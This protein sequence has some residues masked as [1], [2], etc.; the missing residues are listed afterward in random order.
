MLY[1]SNSAASD[2][3]RAR[4]GLRMIRA[5]QLSAARGKTA[6]WAAERERRSG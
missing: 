3:S 1:K 6:E 4:F 2:V 5:A